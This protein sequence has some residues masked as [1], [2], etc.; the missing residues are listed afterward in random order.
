M[1]S[2]PEVPCV[3]LSSEV[4]EKRHDENSGPEFRQNL[5]FGY[6][7]QGKA[8]TDSH[9]TL[10]GSPWSSDRDLIAARIAEYPVGKTAKCR[11]N[12]A[13]PDFAVLKPDSLAPGYSIWFPGIFVVGGLGITFRAIT[14]R[15]PPP[16]ASS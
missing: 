8:R 14:Y 9:L 15:L 16:R 11:V 7:W 12:P 10:R 4:G 13:D 3:I 5:T 1:H 6:E 2:W